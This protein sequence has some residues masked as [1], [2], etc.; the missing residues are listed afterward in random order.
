[1]AEKDYFGAKLDF[2]LFSFDLQLKI[3]SLV[4]DICR[5]IDSNHI[6][7]PLA[8]PK[9]VATASNLRV[10]DPRSKRKREKQI[11]T[12]LARCVICQCPKTEKADVRMQGQK[13]L[14]ETHIGWRSLH[15]RVA[16]FKTAI[17]SK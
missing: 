11:N 7:N 12:D 1:M 10:L 4:Y 15:D 8:T 14:Y 2:V 13:K 17:S 5:F 3:C 16:L 6:L 9:A